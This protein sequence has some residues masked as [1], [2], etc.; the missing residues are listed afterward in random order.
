[1]L[2][3]S[4]QTPRSSREPTPRTFRMKSPQTM[5]SFRDALSWRRSS[6]A[7]SATASTSDPN[8]EAVT[9]YERRRQQVR[10]AQRERKVFRA[11]TSLELRALHLRSKILSY[12]LNAF[13]Q[14]VAENTTNQSNREQVNPP[15]R[16]GRVINTTE[17]PIDAGPSSYTVNKQ[18]KSGSPLHVIIPESQAE[19]QNPPLLDPDQGVPHRDTSSPGSSS[20]NNTHMP[21]NDALQSGES[22]ALVEMLSG[23]S[24]DKIIGIDFVL[25][26][27][28]PCMTH[29]DMT[30][31]E[32]GTHSHMPTH[33]LLAYAPQD[34][35]GSANWEVPGADIKRL[36]NMS[37]NFQLQGEITPV[38]AWVSSKIPAVY[39]HSLQAP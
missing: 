10:R 26:L 33:T 28:H 18:S 4:S 3:S 12:D 11:W 19:M 16:Q 2:R 30:R 14:I 7:K 21:S 35:R 39:L 17:E 22:T 15:A 34:L 25:A 32:F 5:S 1:M 6:K 31:D 8:D 20:D 37:N 13:A 38:Q 24:L 36:L 29:V 9:A 23:G 27:E